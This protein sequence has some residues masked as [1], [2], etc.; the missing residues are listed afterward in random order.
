MMSN[1]NNSLSV[2]WISIKL[3]KAAPVRLRPGANLKN[4]WKKGRQK[5]AVP[6]LMRA[7][8]V[9]KGAGF[10][11]VEATWAA[12]EG[13]GGLDDE[14]YV[15]QGAE[16]KSGDGAAVDGGDGR[17]DSGCEVQGGGIV[18]IVHDG[19]AHEGGGLEKG[20]LAAEV[21]DPGRAGGG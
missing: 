19:G 7:I 2:H 16:A 9:P 12:F 13:F 3:T 6:D 21:D 5:L 18:D 1:T 15:R 11:A 10:V 8:K 14:S 20:Q 17:I 4:V